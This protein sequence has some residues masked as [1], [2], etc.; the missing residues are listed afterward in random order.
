VGC[1]DCRTCT[2]SKVFRG[3]RGLLLVWWV[4]LPKLFMRNCPQCGHT[5]RRHRYR[6]DGSFRD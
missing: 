5:L 1:R 2:M 4:W 3:L 6:E